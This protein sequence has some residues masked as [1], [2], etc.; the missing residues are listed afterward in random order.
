MALHHAVADGAVIGVPDAE[1]GQQVKATIEFA[2]GSAPG[3]GLVAHVRARLCGH[4]SRA[5][6]TC[7]RPHLSRMTSPLART[8][9]PL[10]EFTES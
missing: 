1:M 4:K 10:R 7:P 2:P 8:T 6:W 9:S 3:E 5:A